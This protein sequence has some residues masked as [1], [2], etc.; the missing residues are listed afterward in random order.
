M[1][2]RLDAGDGDL[3]RKV[4]C[5]DA[6]PLPNVSCVRVSRLSQILDL[7]AEDNRLNV[8]AGKL[9][10]RPPGAPTTESDFRMSLNV[11]VSARA[12]R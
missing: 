2:I 7:L 12:S 8:Y 4:S 5:R 11:A 9:D 1:E 10:V 6:G 3:R